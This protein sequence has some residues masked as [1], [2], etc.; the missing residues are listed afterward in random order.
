MSYQEIAGRRVPVDSRYLLGRGDAA[1]PGIRVPACGYRP[2]RELIIDP[3]IRYTTFLGG[4]SHEI[5]AGI[6]V[7]AA[8]NAYIAGTTQSPNFPTTAGAFKRTGAASNFSDVFV[9]KLNAAGHGAGLF[10]VHRRQRL[11]LRAPD[12]DRRRGQRLRHRPDEVVE[13]PDHRRRVRPQ[14]QHPGNCPRCGDR[15]LRRASSTKLNAAGSALVYSTFLGGTD[16]DDARGIAVDGGGQRLRHRRDAVGELPDDRRRLSADRR[17]AYD[18]FVTKLNAAG[19]ALVYSTFLGGTQVD[20]GERIAVDAGGNAYVVGFTSSADFPTTAGAFDTTA[21]GALRRVRDE[22]E[23]GRLGARLL[24][25]P[26]RRGFDGGGGLA[27][28][29]AGKRYVRAA[30]GSL[31]L[32]DHGR[33][34]R[35]AAGRQRRLRDEAERRR[36]GARVLDACSA[37]RTATA[38]RRDR[39]SMRHGNAWLDGRHELGR[40]PDDRRR[41]RRRST[42][43][44]DAF[45]S[46][47]SADGVDAPVLDLSRRLAVG[48]RERPRA[49]TGAATSTSPA[50]PTRWTSPRRSARSTRIF[51]GDLPIFWGDAFVTKIDD[52]R[53]DRR[54]ARAAGAAGRP[55]L[56]AP[57]NGETPPQPITF[58]W[59]DV[60][61]AASYTI[62]IDDSSAFTAPL[63]REQTS[64]RRCT[65]RGTRGDDALLARARRERR[66][67]GRARGRPCAASRR[68]RR[69]LPATLGS[70]DD[71]SVDGRRRE[72]LERD[73]RPQ[74]R[75]PGR[76]R[77]HRAVEQ[78]SGGGQRARRRSPRRRT[79]SPPRS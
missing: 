39:S 36:V 33:R 73:G 56:L 16:I 22:A 8:G 70:L 71:Q 64:R 55:A 74:R 76:R 7:D 52:R 2:D 46:E 15:Q 58:D 51:N 23:R 13:F 41:R 66:R 63:V 1:R 53:A 62:Q 77:G 29:A 38:R 26:R 9:S 48:G 57:A 27:V 30:T 6:A 3:G 24:H 31:E 32:P 69:R 12:R 79:R 40:L 54:P 60:T 20:N 5:G 72:C 47:L 65:R 18:V 42:A 34:V 4:A 25:L 61:S 35:H 17:G 11:R 28:D 44:A 21:N 67:R 68:R 50:T 59:S 45:V 49:S 37:A 10:D 43:S 78:Q 19:T 14:L 75:A